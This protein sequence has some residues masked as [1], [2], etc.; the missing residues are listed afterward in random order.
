MRNLAERVPQRVK[1]MTLGGAVIRLNIRSRLLV[2]LGNLFKNYVPY[3]WLYRL[4]AYV[5]MP[6]PR[7]AESRNLFVREARKLC[8]REFKRWFELTSEVTP[9]MRYFREKELRIPTLYIMGEDDYMF[10]NAV[11][12]V[13]KRHHSA[14]LSVIK[15]CGHVC[16]VESPSEFNRRSLEFF[17]RHSQL[18]CST[19]A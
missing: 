3:M 18:S 10:L 13:V 14:T 17:A 7:N 5:I 15:R 1:S 2:S 12:E 6:S 4:F 19:A 8:Q 9:L 16:N 11:K